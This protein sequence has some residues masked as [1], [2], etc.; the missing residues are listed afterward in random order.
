MSNNRSVL[1]V[2]DEADALL[3]L[4]RTLSSYLNDSKIVGAGTKDKAIEVFK[5]HKPHCCV[6][7]LELNK[8]EGVNA[9]FSLI[10]SLLSLDPD[11]RII[12][13]TGH[14][15]IEY[16]IESVRRGATSFIEKPKGDGAWINAGFFVCQPEVLNY[17]SDN[18]TVFEK[19]PLETLASEGELYT[20][21]HEGF[22]KCMDT[23]RDKEELELLWQTEPLW[24]KW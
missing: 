2:D 11:L 19:D 18:Q 10:S 8:T 24:K 4:S 5:E 1:L 14:S 13:L 17:I 12:V 9:G 7:D 6:V 23:L 16:G 3:S 15:A 21:H 20:F 22:W